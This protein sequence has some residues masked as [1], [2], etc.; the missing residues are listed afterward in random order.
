L[1]KGDKGGFS[2]ILV[3]ISLNLPLKKGEV[4]VSC[5]K[6]RSFILRQA[7]NERREELAMTDRIAG[8]LNLV[9]AKNLC[10]TK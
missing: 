1:E 10:H 8:A 6:E 2:C 5:M 9:K 3:K 7:Q 4:V